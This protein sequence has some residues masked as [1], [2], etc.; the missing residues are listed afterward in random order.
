MAKRAAARAK[1]ELQ[2]G[3]KEGGDLLTHGG[4][5]VH[6]LGG[7]QHGR[8]QRPPRPPRNAARQR[9]PPP[10]R[11]AAQGEPLLGRYIQLRAG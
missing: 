1:G 3:L 2:R 7:R 9:Q 11:K 6:E 8:A 10:V 4:G 5:G